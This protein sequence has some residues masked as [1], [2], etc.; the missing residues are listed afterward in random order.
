MFPFTFFV[1]MFTIIV[2]AHDGVGSKPPSSG[3]T[4]GVVKATFSLSL[5]E[6]PRDLFFPGGSLI[7]YPS[8]ISGIFYTIHCPHVCI[9]V[10]TQKVP[11]PKKR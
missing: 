7:F 10:S 8:Y 3:W 1:N 5:P 2:Y 6:D 9:E 11:F 4:D